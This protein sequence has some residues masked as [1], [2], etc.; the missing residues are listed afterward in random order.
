VKSNPPEKASA[1]GAISRTQGDSTQGLY[2]KTPSLQ[3]SDDLAMVYIMRDSTCMGRFTSGHVERT[4]PR[5]LRVY[6]RNGVF[7]EYFS[8]PRLRSWCVFG[9]EG[10]QVEA[11]SEVTPEDSPRIFSQPS[12]I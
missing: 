5:G 10:R 12:G 2:A 7:L 4:G 6:D 8:G 1:L 11:W 9:P 3:L